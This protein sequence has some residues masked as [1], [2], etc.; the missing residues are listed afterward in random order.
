MYI[1]NNSKL[2]HIADCWVPFFIEDVAHVKFKNFNI[3]Q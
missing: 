3:A 1:N 2:L